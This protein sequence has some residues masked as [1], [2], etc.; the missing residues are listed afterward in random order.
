MINTPIIKI[1]SK[2]R[3]AMPLAILMSLS[4]GDAPGYINVAPLGL[5]YELSPL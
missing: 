5:F 3:G 2:A 4:R 1:K